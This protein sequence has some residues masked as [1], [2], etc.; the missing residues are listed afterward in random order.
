MDISPLVAARNPANLFQLG[1]AIA[2]HAGQANDLTC[3]N[4][5]ADIT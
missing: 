4:L 2:C 3:T 5:Q 1:L